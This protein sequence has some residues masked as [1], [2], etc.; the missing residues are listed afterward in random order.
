MVFTACKGLTVCR[1]LSFEGVID[2]VVTDLSQV[3]VWFEEPEDKLG[4]ISFG[5]GVGYTY[6]GVRKRGSVVRFLFAKGDFSEQEFMEL[7]SRH[8][9]ADAQLTF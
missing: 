5:H 4:A 9:F 7:L 2:E 1:K 6:V 8:K 3:W